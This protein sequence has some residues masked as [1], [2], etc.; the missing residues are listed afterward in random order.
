MLTWNRGLVSC[1][2]GSGDYRVL[3]WS[4]YS[5]LRRI[6]SILLLSLG[7]F[8][9]KGWS[10]TRGSNLRISPDFIIGIIDPRLLNLRAGQ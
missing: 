10:T 8:V 1:S 6:R 9:Q 5:S 3:F 2:R 4:S 7:A